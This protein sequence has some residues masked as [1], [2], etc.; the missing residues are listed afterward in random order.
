V[1]RLSAMH[2]T[3]ANLNRGRHRL[4]ALACISIVAGCAGATERPSAE[5][6]RARSLI[7]QAG[8]QDTQQFAAAELELARDK[9]KR[10]EQAV[11]DGREAEAERLA[12]QAG[13]DAEYASVKAN[14]VKA[15]KAADELAKSLET[16]R[17]ESARRPTQ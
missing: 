3:S 9:L 11:E 10:A 17:Q 1:H 16:L 2:R 4:A 5:L 6:T 12:M 15:Q 14:N 7:D 8:K 13:L